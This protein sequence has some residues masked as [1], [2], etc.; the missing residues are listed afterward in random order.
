M[1]C[2]RDIIEHTENESRH[3][4]DEAVTSILSDSVMNRLEHA[5]YMMDNKQDTLNIIESLKEEFGNDIKGKAGLTALSFAKESYSFW[6]DVY[7]E[8]DHPLNRRL[9]ILDLPTCLAESLVSGVTSVVQS[10]FNGESTAQTLF[11]AI[12]A[13]VNFIRTCNTSSPSV[14]HSD[15]PTKSPTS[16]P[17][18]NPTAPP[19]NSITNSTSAPTVT[20]LT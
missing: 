11:T 9:Q 6:F 4:K 20:P 15:A 1:G 8:K 14:S 16:T 19:T 3:K 10:V 17:T 5:M 12:S 7:S 13:L 18:K 2:I